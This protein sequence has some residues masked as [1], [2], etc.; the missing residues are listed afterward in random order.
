MQANER[1]RLASQYRRAGVELLRLSRELDQTSYRKWIST[2][3]LWEERDHALQGACEQLW[4]WLF[5]EPW[6]SGVRCRW[7]RRSND[8]YGWAE[9]DGAKNGGELLISWKLANGEKYPLIAVLH[10]FA[11]LRGYNH[12]KEMDSTLTRWARKCSIEPSLVPA[13]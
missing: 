3:R 9:L 2:I 12:G 7:T 8:Y 6:P 11:H 1:R 10:E 13:T 4:R 5:S